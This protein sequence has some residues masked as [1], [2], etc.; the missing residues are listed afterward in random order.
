MHNN[1]QQ[2]VDYLAVSNNFSGLPDS[3]A[4]ERREQYD[5][6]VERLAQVLAAGSHFS[7]T[8]RG[9]APAAG[10]VATPGAAVETAAAAEVSATAAAAARGRKPFTFP[11]LLLEMRTGPLPTRGGAYGTIA[12]QRRLGAA[13][14]QAIR[15]V[16]S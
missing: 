5:V 9:G 16:L 12:D 15:T 1:N 4:G 8:V 2:T 7:G 10:A 3:V 14:G 13:L 6:L 11:S